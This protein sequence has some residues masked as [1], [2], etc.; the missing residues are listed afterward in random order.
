MEPIP[1]SNNNNGIISET[2]IHCIDGRQR[3]VATTNNNYE[4]NSG[5]EL[6]AIPC[7]GDPSSIS[8]PASPSLFFFFLLRSFSSGSAAAAAGAD[9]LL[10]R[11]AERPRSR[12]RV[13]RSEAE[14]REAPE[15]GS[16]RVSPIVGIPPEVPQYAYR[17]L[18]VTPQ[19]TDAASQSRRISRQRSQTAD[20]GGG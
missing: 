1:K 20:S 6:I 18:Q 13:E 12:P 7:C 17:I 5:P 4:L 2:V 16:C 19:L 8:S 11:G 9:P 14:R 3:E 10:G 15:E